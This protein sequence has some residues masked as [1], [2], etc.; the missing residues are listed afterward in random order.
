[1]EYPNPITH[2][3]YTELTTTSRNHC[4]RGGSSQLQT[5]LLQRGK[6][7]VVYRSPRSFKCSAKHKNWVRLLAEQPSF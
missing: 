4:L 6:E 5:L 7:C 1:M 3:L 2:A